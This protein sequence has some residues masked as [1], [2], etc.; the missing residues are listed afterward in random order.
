LPSCTNRP[1]SKTSGRKQTGTTIKKISIINGLTSAPNITAMKVTTVTI[2]ITHITGTPV[3]K[4]P[5]L[6]PA[7]LLSDRCK[8]TD[9]PAIIARFT[10]A[11]TAMCR[12]WL[13]HLIVAG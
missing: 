1:I 7:I 3:N 8:K 9:I 12:F 4:G 10:A 11:Q 5:I 13:Q 6:N 2:D